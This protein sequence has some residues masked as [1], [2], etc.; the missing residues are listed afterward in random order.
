MSKCEHEVY[1]AGAFWKCKRPGCEETIS[2]AI[3][4]N[5]LMVK[6]E[7]KAVENMPPIEKARKE[8]K[9]KLI[10]DLHKAIDEA[11]TDIGTGLDQGDVIGCIEWVKQEY[12]DE[13]F[14]NE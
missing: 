8:I 4:A 10:K 9:D 14:R 3:A 2:H 5:S 6:L 11:R 13:C 12:I 1:K 7:A